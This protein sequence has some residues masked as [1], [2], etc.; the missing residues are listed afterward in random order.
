MF[1]YFQTFHSISNSVFEVKEPSHFQ[2]IKHE[3]KS[4]KEQNK[5]I[6]KLHNGVSL[7]IFLIKFSL[8]KLIIKMFINFIII[9]FSILQF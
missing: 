9:L 8:V 6:S 2:N 5:N 3:N 4:T 1:V 7:I